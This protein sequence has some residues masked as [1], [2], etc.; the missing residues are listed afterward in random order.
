MKIVCFKANKGTKECLKEKKKR[1]DKQQYIIKN[2]YLEAPRGV[3][4]FTRKYQIKE[5]CQL[6]DRHRCSWTQLLKI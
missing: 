2:K 1:K 6:L 5:I 3:S 4:K